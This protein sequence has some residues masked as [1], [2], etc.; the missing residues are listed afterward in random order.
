ML[1][2]IVLFCIIIDCIAISFGIGVWYASFPIA[3]VLIFYVLVVDYECKNILELSET[4]KPCGYSSI[5][6]GALNSFHDQDLV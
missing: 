5:T 3:I 1:M 2:I 6:F 4:E